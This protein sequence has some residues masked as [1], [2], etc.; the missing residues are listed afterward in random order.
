MPSGPHGWVSPCRATCVTLFTF[1]RIGVFLLLIPDLASCQGVG[2]ILSEEGDNMA[3]WWSQ[4]RV[5]R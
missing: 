5:Q 2:C 4:G 1:V 3:A